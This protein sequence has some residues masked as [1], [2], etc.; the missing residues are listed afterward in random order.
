MFG[1]KENDIDGT[2]GWD[3]NDNDEMTASWAALTS[4]TTWNK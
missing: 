4:T 2:H 3:G 1:G